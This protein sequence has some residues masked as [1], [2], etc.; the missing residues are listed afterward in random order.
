M[1][2]YTG[3]DCYFIVLDISKDPSLANGFAVFKFL[4]S[5][6]SGCHNSPFVRE[7]LQFVGFNSLI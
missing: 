5:Q 4:A 7:Y 1:E 6:S 2:G 3:S